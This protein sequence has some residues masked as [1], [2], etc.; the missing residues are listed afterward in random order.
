MSALRTAATRSTLG[1]FLGVLASSPAFGL[2]QRTFVASYGNDANP[3]SLALP[4]RAFSSAI[5]K[6]IDGGEVIALDS[7]AYGPVTI[8]QSVSIIGS[9]GAYVGLSVIAPASTVGVTINGA[10]IKVVLQNIAI[11]ALG[12]TY[13]IRIL[14]AAEVNVSGCA[15]SNFT[16]AGIYATAANA[17]LSLRDTLVRGSRGA[18]APGI[19]LAADMRA[20]LE[21]ARVV[22]N[23]GAGVRIEGG[24]NVSMTG[25]VVAGNG[26]AGISVSA[27][28]AVFSVIAVEDSLVADNAG[29]GIAAQ[30]AT[31]AGAVAEAAAARSSITR[32]GGHGVSVA[33]TAPG[34]AVATLS[35]S[36][37]SQQTLDGLWVSG[38]GALAT[39]SN[40]T[41]AGNGSSA[42]HALAGGAIHTV[43]GADGLPNNSGEQT[44]PTIGN[45]VPAS[46]F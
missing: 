21:R 22:R 7:A 24:A 43:K 32:N 27:P 5:A 8:S 4:C 39:A 23:A 13:G 17:N 37:V 15:I 40:N 20:T 2:A 28:A 12:G 34:S 10:G 46:A 36:L 18:A 16:G 6:V 38:A 33:S 31:V 29:D 41:F 14:Q 45:V 3:C 1:F 9:A 25:S 19:W 42:L 35:D 26:G 30:A 44:T 11:N